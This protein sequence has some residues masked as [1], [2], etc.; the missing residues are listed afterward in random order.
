[1]GR[2]KRRGTSGQDRPGH[3]LCGRQSEASALPLLRRCRR[4]LRLGDELASM[5]SR[6]RE[7]LSSVPIDGDGANL[8]FSSGALWVAEGISGKVTRIDPKSDA[9]SSFVTGGLVLNVGARRAG[10]RGRR[11]RTARPHEGSEGPDPSRP[12]ALGQPEAHR[13]RHRRSRRCAALARAARVR[14]LREPAQLPGRARTV[15]WRLVP[16]IAAALPSVSP[17]GQETHVPDPPW[18]QVLTALER[19]RN[20]RNVPLHDRTRSL[21]SWDNAQPARFLPDVVGLKAFRSGRTAHIRGIVVRGNRLSIT[22]EKPAADLMTRIAVPA[23]CPVPIGTP[24][25]PNGLPEEPDPVRRDPT[26]SPRTWAATRP[27][28]GATRTT[29]GHVRTGSRQSSTRWRVRRRRPSIA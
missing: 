25:V 13:S 3:E 27:C 29:E 15:G 9:T 4:R 17:D 21:T 24:I 26:T 28:F 2:R 23:F 5:G 1:M 7:I 14:D 6:R 12:D 20:G 11:R 16:E 8:T 18:V 22:L 10:R 19:T